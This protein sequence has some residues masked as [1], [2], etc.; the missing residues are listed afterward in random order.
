MVVGYGGPF[1]WCRGPTVYCS[2]EIAW[3]R[4]R[5][6]TCTVSG[7]CG[8]YP[9]RLCWWA[10]GLKVGIMAA[11]T[12]PTVTTRGYA[13]FTFRADDAG[14]ES[15]G[16]ARG[17]EASVAQIPRLAAYLQ[18]AGSSQRVAEFLGKNGFQQTSIQTLAPGLASGERIGISNEPVSQGV[19]ELWMDNG[20][21]ESGRG[22]ENSGGPH[23]YGCRRSIC[24]GRGS[25]DPFAPN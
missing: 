16:T 22:D 25:G 24:L 23:S 4:A 11:G 13:V 8:G 6:T 15:A 17:A 3:R 10:S 20:D 5:P 12:G 14:Q 9:W 7:D 18:I 2:K 19:V 21:L 1:S